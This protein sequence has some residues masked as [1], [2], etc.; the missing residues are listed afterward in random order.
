[1][2]ELAGF[3]GRQGLVGAV[4]DMGPRDHITVGPDLVETAGLERPGPAI[5]VN[6]AAA[7]NH[8]AA[9]IEVN[10][11][12]RIV[13]D[14]PARTCL[15]SHRGLNAQTR[16]GVTEILTT[17]LL[18]S[19]VLT[20]GLGQGTVGTVADQATNERGDDLLAADP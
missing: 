5:D 15:V 19:E 13:A 9:A 4:V 16:D 12:V 20:D 10:A 3:G 8:E 14:A 1:M 2:G 17:E 18:I 6:R 7:V 11:V